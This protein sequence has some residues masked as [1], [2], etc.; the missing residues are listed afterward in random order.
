MN[1]LFAFFFSL[2]TLLPAFAQQKCE[3]VAAFTDRDCYLAGERLYVCLDV[4]L[5]GEPSPSRV[6]Y[7]EIADTRQMVAQAMV[8]LE[9]GKGW[10]EIDLPQQMHSG[11]YQLAAYT[12]AM[13]NFGPEAFHRSIIGIINGHQLSL[14]DDIL[15]LPSDSID[16]A[17][18]QSLDIASIPNHYQPG[19]SIEL[20]LPGECALS[21]CRM[22]I[23]AVW[24]QATIDSQR[25]S[26]RQQ[27]AAD[28]QQQVS[29]YTPEVEGHIVCAKVSPGIQAEVEHSRMAL[30]GQQAT[31]YDG[32]PQGDG[33]FL[34]YTSGIVGS[35]PM[36]VN[37]FDTLGQMVPM[38]PLSPYAA[39]LPRT[40][41]QLTVCCQE[42]ELLHR[43][44]AANQQVVV[45]Q[46][47]QAKPLPH[48]VGFMS[49]EPDFF[50]DLDEYTQMN[51]VR[52]LLLEFVR[53][54]HRQ[55]VH[56]INRLYTFDAEA[57]R[58][59]QWP[60]L[61]LLD[62]MPVYDIDEILHYDA[63]LIRYVQIYSGIFNFGNSCCKG[64]ISF[65]TRGGRLSNY[66][67]KAGEQLMA[68]AFPQD[69]P[70]FVNHTASAYSTLLWIPRVSQQQITIEAPTLP[71]EYQI[72][73]QGIDATG[74]TF[75]EV[76][77][78]VVN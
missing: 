26:G 56:G 51:D 78:F 10:A 2:L 36:M 17:S 33:S 5:D 42:E 69:H 19:Q 65:I 38:M 13:R 20:Q 41:P 14:H 40:L 66:K 59:S 4:C 45:S 58:Y 60:A 18:T 22:G 54:I 77:T 35:Q 37:A 73:M 47:M 72:I 76:K 49:A 24:P 30:V 29:S 75:R 67:L 28:L 8:T 1:R 25:A 74:R 68:Y 63:H 27:S 12:R 3:Q 55:K 21:L 50:Y 44:T 32:Q 7:I 64:V 15:F 70:K 39:I 52:E 53:G 31:L 6:A 11:C 43:A 62:G 34:F 23:Q 61:V 16:M 71:G 57:G 9:Q 48:S 46:S